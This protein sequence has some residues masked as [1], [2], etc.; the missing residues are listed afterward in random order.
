MAFA[1]STSATLPLC[2]HSTRGFTSRRPLAFSKRRGGVVTSAKK[3]KDVLF[4]R[5]T[6][7]PLP[8]SYD[9]QDDEEDF[10]S[11]ACALAYATVDNEAHPS[12]SLIQVDVSAVPGVMR[13]LSW[14]L[15]GLD[16]QLK[17]ADWEIEE[18]GS[19]D[20]EEVN[21]V[22]HIRMWVVEGYGKNLRKIE[23]PSCVEDRVTEYLRFCTNA[24][25]RKH[26][27]IE[28]RG[29]K[30]D[31]VSNPERTLVTVS[32][33]ENGAESL[34]SMASTVTGL[35]LRM[36]HAK[37]DLKEELGGLSSATWKMQVTDFDSRQKLSNTQVQ[38]LL[39]TLALVFNKNKD[40]GFGGADYLV[41]KLTNEDEVQV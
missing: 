29:I 15:N 11:P 14:L 40:G 2:F 9:S 8:P 41:E 35:N 36:N 20:E 31:N 10:G 24:E 30:I 32:S 39:Y 6:N 25:R 4:G 28:H 16:L 22:V 37:L 18:L 5:E 27:V 21:D 26:A 33:R 1:C 7:P 23:D 12:W 38:G 19:Q 13:I 34:L 3:K 17:E